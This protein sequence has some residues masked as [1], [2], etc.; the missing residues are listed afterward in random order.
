[1]D[2]F[3]LATRDGRFLRITEGRKSLVSEKAKAYKFVLPPNPEY[4]QE[5]RRQNQATNYSVLM[6]EDLI[7]VNA[8]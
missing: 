8:S 1:M 7:A 5:M 6:H 2:S 4:I 3:Y